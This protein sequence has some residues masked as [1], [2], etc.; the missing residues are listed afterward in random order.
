MAALRSAHRHVNR[1]ASTSMV[2]GDWTCLIGA[3][4]SDIAP[5]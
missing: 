5:Y 3:L 1:L 4:I 2:R